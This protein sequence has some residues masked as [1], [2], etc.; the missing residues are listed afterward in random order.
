MTRTLDIGEDWTGHKLAHGGFRHIWKVVSDDGKFL[1]LVDA[2]GMEEGFIY[3]DNLRGWCGVA[4]DEPPERALR[5]DSA[6]AFAYGV[7]A[8]GWDMAKPEPVNPLSDGVLVYYQ[9]DEFV[10][11][12]ENWSFL[13]TLPPIDT[14]I[15]LDAVTAFLKASPL[16]NKG[17][18][19]LS[20]CDVLERS[21]KPN[22]MG[23]W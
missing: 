13:G 22:A 10:A 7:A 19:L 1:R 20:A 2:T 11:F 4:A 17:G 21:V 15:A 14:C 23:R 5:D 18:Q 8:I 9:G 6:D 12:D 3:K 16:S